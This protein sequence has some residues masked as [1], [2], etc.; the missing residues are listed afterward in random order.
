VHSGYVEDKLAFFNTRKLK[1]R[2]PTLLPLCLLTYKFEA[3]TSNV[4]N[5]EWFKFLDPILSCFETNKKA[6]SQPHAHNLQGNYQVSARMRFHSRC[7]NI[8]IVLKFS[9]HVIAI[10]G[11]VPTMALQTT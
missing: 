4:F 3:L 11:L 1:A 5:S 8:Y 6:F 7:L 2:A 10:A 9:A